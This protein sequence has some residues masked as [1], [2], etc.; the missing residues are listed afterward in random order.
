[1]AAG[2]RTLI[3]AEYVQR[4]AP[5]GVFWQS[6]GASRRRMNQKAREILAAIGAETILPETVVDRLSFEERKL[7]E[8]ARAL[9]DAPD[10]L[11]VDETTTALSMEGR[12]T[13]YQIIEKMKKENKT[14]IFISHDLEEVV[15]ICDSASVLRDGKFIK[16]I[17]KEEMTPDY[18]RTLMIGREL[19]GH[20]YMGDRKRQDEN[21]IVLK[22][23]GI[24]WGNKLK[25]VSIE[26]RR[27]EIL[28]LG[29]LTECGMHE[30]CKVIFGA[31]RP[32]S[33]SVEVICDGSAKKIHS[34][35]DA[36]NNKVAYLPKD[37]DA[38][39]LFTAASIQDNMTVTASEQ[40]K[41]GIYL[42]PKKEEALA[43]E[44]VQSL[45]IKCSSEKQYVNELSG[46]NKQKVVVGKWLA[47]HSEILIMDCPT[48][49]I[50]VGVK[51]AI[52]HLMERLTLEGKSIIMVSEEMPELIGMSDRIIVLKNGE[53][54]GT[55]L[56]SQK[57][58]E[59]DLV[60]CII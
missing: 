40:V 14:V 33:G 39:S 48:R 56:R 45:S 7:I 2:K 43:K 6:C 44:Y 26:L 51:K 16:T 52:Y 37:R 59:N 3:F 25:E 35:S 50:D 28:G 22:A 32:D 55:F 19:D 4:K 1:M 23:S 27:G 36:I 54:M 11:I 17:H 38:E 15:R 29:G 30:L 42:S 57:V 47:N 8:V 34:C 12:N 53:V 10:L 31:I 5:P 21:D 20:Y 46:G 41:K 9:L 49:G 18:L 60:S 58:T 13:I 24:T